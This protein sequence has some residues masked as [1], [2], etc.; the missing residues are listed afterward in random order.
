MAHPR[1][2]FGARAVDFARL[3]AGGDGLSPVM[4]AT[5]IY[6]DAINIFL[7][8]CRSSGGGGRRT[9]ASR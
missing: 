8:L 3:R 2:L 6:L 4:M 5:S 7:A 1:H 9:R